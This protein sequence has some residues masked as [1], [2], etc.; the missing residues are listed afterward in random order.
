M[1]DHKTRRQAPEPKRI[2][3]ADGYELIY[4]KR[5]LGC[6]EQQLRAAIAATGPEVEQVRVYLKAHR[7]GPDPKLACA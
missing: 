5:Q 3:A 6:T 2:N 4:W 1:N 7:P